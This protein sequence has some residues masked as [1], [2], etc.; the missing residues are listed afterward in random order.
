MTIQLM[1]CVDTKDG[2]E[3]CIVVCLYEKTNE[4][5]IVGPGGI[6]KNYK[7]EDL[8]KNNDGAPSPEALIDH[9]TA[10]QWKQLIDGG[11]MDVAKLIY[12]NT[13]AAYGLKRRVAK[14]S[15]DLSRLV[16]E[17]SRHLKID[18]K[19]EDDES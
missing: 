18:I 16:R 15:Y 2:K 11:H 10:E 7:T 6:Y 3:F 5:L 1:D 13:V 4:A 12:R 19:L 9:P 17:L 14:V 8:K